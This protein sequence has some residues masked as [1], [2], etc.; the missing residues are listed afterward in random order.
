[1]TRENLIQKA[2]KIVDD[3]FI[4]ENT[5]IAIDTITELFSANGFTFYDYL[6]ARLEIFSNVL[7]IESEE[8]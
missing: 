2:R 1:M 6:E 4:N 8:V 7:S 3:N 5:D